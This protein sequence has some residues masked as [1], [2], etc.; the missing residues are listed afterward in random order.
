[1]MSTIRKI[2]VGRVQCWDLQEL[3]LCWVIREGLAYKMMFEG[4]EEANHEAAFGSVPGGG[5]S[6]GPG[7]G[8]CLAVG[9]VARWPMC[10]E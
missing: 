2:R 5:K 4:T 3:I 9:G 7:V 1:M 10:M 8:T 6:K